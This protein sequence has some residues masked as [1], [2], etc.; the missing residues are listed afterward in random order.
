MGLLHYVTQLCSTST[1]FFTVPYQQP[2][3]AQVIQCQSSNATEFSEY[4]RLCIFKMETITTVRQH[5]N[6]CNKFSWYNYY[7]RQRTPS[8]VMWHECFV[9]ST[10]HE[11]WRSYSFYQHNIFL[12]SLFQCFLSCA[13]KKHVKIKG[14]D[15][16][17]TNTIIAHK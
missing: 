7:L 12:T 4:T 6:K 14:I 9:V 11:K 17:A 10:R 13:T 2:T 15:L 16:T 8:Q 1:C 5:G 3:Y